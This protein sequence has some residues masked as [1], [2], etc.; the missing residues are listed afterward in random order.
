MDNKYER[1]HVTWSFSSLKSSRISSTHY[2]YFT[3]NADVASVRDR[4]QGVLAMH[5]LWPDFTVYHDW[6]K[7]KF[8]VVVACFVLAIINYNYG[9]AIINSSGDYILL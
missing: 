9:L 4:E 8:P 6:I 7:S 3:R 2:T 5:E 1:L